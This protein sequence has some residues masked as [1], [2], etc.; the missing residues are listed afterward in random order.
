MATSV[1]AG[2]DGFNSNIIPAGRVASAWVNFQGDSTVVI[3]DSFNVSSIT[4]QATG[5][6]V[7][8]FTA[9]MADI[10]YASLCTLTRNAAANH[11]GTIAAEGEKVKLVGSD[12]F[13]TNFSSSTSEGAF[14]PNVVNYIAFGGV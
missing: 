11:S 6:Y 10:N 1:I 8:N 5:E 9:N 2:D 14:D 3:R 4:D 13:F 7:I 12:T